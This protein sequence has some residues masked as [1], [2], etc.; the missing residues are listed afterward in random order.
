[1]QINTAIPKRQKGSQD[2]RV[3]A[4]LAFADAKEKTL[5]VLATIAFASVAAA[6]RQATQAAS[7]TRPPVGRHPIGIDLDQHDR[8]NVVAAYGTL[9][10]CGRLECPFM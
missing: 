2:P 6:Q 4:R 7:E 5:E 1:M 8:G 3:A 9:F 10:D